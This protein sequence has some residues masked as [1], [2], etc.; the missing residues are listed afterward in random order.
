MIPPLAT[1]LPPNA[2]FWDLLLYQGIGLAVVLTTLGALA[3]ICGLMGRAFRAATPRAVP[4]TSPTNAATTPAPQADI[5]PH[6]TV[7]IAAAV[8]T[9]IQHPHRIATVRHIESSPDWT[10]FMLSTWSV[11]GRA[12]IFSSHRIR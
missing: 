7:I 9:L 3:L 5:P 2:G 1:T 12:A 4:T 11:E 8:A 10:R 6:H